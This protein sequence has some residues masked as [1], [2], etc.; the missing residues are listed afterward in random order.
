MAS[1][2]RKQAVPTLA[3]RING[4]IQQ[5]YALDDETDAIIDAW[6]DEYERG[7]P[8]VPKGTLRMME[9]DARSTAY[10]HRE[11]LLRLRSKL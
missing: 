2:A 8:G 1:P 6:V 11:A 3:E 7:C 4:L 9:L 5:Y 10:C